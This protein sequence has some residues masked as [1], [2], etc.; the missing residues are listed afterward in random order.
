MYNPLVVIKSASLAKTYLLP[1]YLP[2]SIPI[3][4]YE[5]GIRNAGFWCDNIYWRHDNMLWMAKP[6]DTV[7]S[8]MKIPVQLS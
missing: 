3:D 4:L 5:Y 1:F 8:H 6:F 7:T 2:K